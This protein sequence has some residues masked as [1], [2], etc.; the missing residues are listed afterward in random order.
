MEDNYDFS[1]AKKGPIAPKGTKVQKTFRLDP[2]VLEWLVVEGE[3]EGIGYQTFL[4]NFLRN[5]MKTPA[6]L[7]GKN[8]DFT[9]QTLEAIFSFILKQ[10][11]SNFKHVETICSNFTRQRHATI[12]HFTYKQ[13]FHSLQSKHLNL[14]PVGKYGPQEE[15]DEEFQIPQFIKSAMGGR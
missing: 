9:G 14:P 1:D 2:D 11:E 4:N 10:Q 6:Q 12:P 8:L 15:D 13:M 5:A 3:K 7:S